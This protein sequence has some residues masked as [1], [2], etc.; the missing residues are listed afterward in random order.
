MKVIDWLLEGDPAI[1]WQVL[2]DL[3][4]AAAEDVAA[5][6]ARVENERGVLPGVL[7]RR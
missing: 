5:E 4:D 3:T 7:P 1:R 2:H 6:R